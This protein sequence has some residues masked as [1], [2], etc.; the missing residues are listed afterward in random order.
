MIATEAVAVI[1]L[2]AGTSTRFGPRDKL[3]EPL[4]GLPL[5]LHVARTLSQLPFAAKVVVTA[6]GGPDFSVCGFR[7]E[8]N[9]DPAAGQS[10]SIRLGL[11]RA[12]RVEPQAVLIVLAD[13][14][15]VTLPHVRSLLARLDEA[16]SVV[17]STDG[18]R[19]CPPALFGRTLFDTLDQVSGDAGGRPLLQTALLVT[20]PAAELVDIDTSSDLLRSADRLRRR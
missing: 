9:R 3:A 13:M 2:A 5:G 17:A 16:H 6:E 7:P 10:G 19:R 18:R 11:A 20:A 15:F 14:P 8:V 1:L 12:R 4:D